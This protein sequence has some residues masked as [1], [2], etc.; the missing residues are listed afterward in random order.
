VS[1]QPRQQKLTGCASHT[2]VRFHFVQ[3]RPGGSRI[4]RRICVNFETFE[5]LT[6]LLCGQT[7]SNNLIPGL[8]QLQTLA[9]TLAR[10]IRTKINFEN[11]NFIVNFAHGICRKKNHISWKSLCWFLSWTNNKSSGENRICVSHNQTGWESIEK[12]PQSNGKHWRTFW[13]Q[14]QIR[15]QYLQNFLLLWWRE[16]SCFVQRISEKTQK[17]PQKE[18]EKALRLKREYFELK[19]TQENEKRSN[20]KR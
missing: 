16:N 3:G 20:K 10:K 2:T 8:A 1:R 7:L 17:T 11:V 4:Q 18:I 19:K 6:Y 14:S 12:I 5:I 9:T 15:F 13:N